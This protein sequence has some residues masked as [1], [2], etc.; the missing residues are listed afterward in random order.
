MG[1][2][3]SWHAME[4]L[5]ALRSETWFKLSDKVI[6]LH[7]SRLH[8][9]HQGLS[10]TQVTRELAGHLGVLHAVLPMANEPVRTIVETTDGDLPFQEYLVRRKCEPR[11][12]SLRFQG[13]ESATLIAE[14]AVALRPDLRGVVVC[15]SNPWMSIGPILSIAPLRHLLSSCA[16]PVLAVTPINGGAGIKGPT[17]R[18]MAELESAVTSQSVAEYY[19]DLVDALV[20][21]DA[22]REVEQHAQRGRPRLIY[23]GTRMENAAD[24]IALAKGCLRIIDGLSQG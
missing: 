19:G 24:C 9:L 1:T 14:I 13:A 7:L 16:A 15:S 21:D 3:E 8:L 10:L 2:K 18:M 23:A 6:A 17:A 22:D 5:G 12:S 20:L 11:V 4:E